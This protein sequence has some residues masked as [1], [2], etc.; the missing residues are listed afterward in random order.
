MASKFSREASGFILTVISAF[1]FASKTVLAKMCYEYGVDA[2]TVLA[3]RMAFAGAIFGAVL[4]WNL[5]RGKWRLDFTGR[6]WLAIVS[7]GIVGYYGSAILDFTGLM[8]IDASLGRM[9]L[10][11]Y[12][13]LVL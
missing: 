4:A 7:L 1:A 2:I 8:Y 11:L 10:F 5:A 9:I 13:T 6:Q 12:P 3:V